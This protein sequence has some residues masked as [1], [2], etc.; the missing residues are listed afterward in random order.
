MDVDEVTDT[1]PMLAQQH[2]LDDDNQNRD[3]EARRYLVKVPTDTPLE[4]DQLASLYTAL[5]L[6]IPAIQQTTLD[7]TL[8]QHAFDQYKH[9]TDAIESGQLQEPVAQTWFDQHKHQQ[10]QFDK[11]WMDK[12]NKQG[13]QTTDKLQVELKGYTTNLIKESIRMAHRDLARHQFTIGDLQGAIKSYTKSREF[14]TTSQH[15]LEMCLGVIEVALEM[16]NYSFIRNYVVKAD[17]ALEAIHQPS[18]SKSKQPQVNLPGMVAPAADPLE[19]AKDKERKATVERLTVVGA[20]AALGQANFDRCAISLTSIGKEAL[21]TKEG[22]ASFFFYAYLWLGYYFIP[23]A[24]IALYATLTG[25]ATFD[26]TQLRNRLLDNVNLRPM[27]D[28]EP[29][30]RDIVRY[31]YSNQFKE[32]LQGLEHHKLRQQLD[33][34]L[35]PHLPTLLDQIESRALLTYFSPFATVSIERMSQAFGWTEGKLVKAVTH[36]IDKGQLE[37]RIDTQLK[38]LVSKNKNQRIEAFKNALKQGELLQR[39]TMASQLRLKLIQHDLVVKM[40]KGRD[41]QSQQHQQQQAVDA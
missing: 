29:H 19:V 36:L 7:T 11:V 8:Y 27:F 20:V 25:L 30:L 10:I 15:V 23:P 14:C 6:V 1:I 21:D 12:A 16:S 28:F 22:H 40:T 18:Q 33:P 37:A 39:R 24:D 9:V 38:I 13:I 17:S 2:Q 4:L 26:R 31:F 41:S 5:S 35:A 3:D 32:G 34:H